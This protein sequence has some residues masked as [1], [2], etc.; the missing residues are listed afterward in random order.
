[1]IGLETFGSWETCSKERSCTHMDLP[2]VPTTLFLKPNPMKMLLRPRRIKSSLEKALPNQDQEGIQ[3]KSPKG[4]LENFHWTRLEGFITNT[5]WKRIG[6][7]HSLQL[8]W[9]WTAPH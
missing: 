9:V 5:S 6:R 2:L 1:M 4:V 8:I 3:R 7:E